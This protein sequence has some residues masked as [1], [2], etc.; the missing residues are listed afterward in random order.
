[1]TQ[2]QTSFHYNMLALIDGI[3]PRILGL[4]DILKEYLKHRQV[5]VR[6][7]TEFELQKA[8]DRAH[9]LEGL[10]IALDH[11][12]EVIAVI[13]GSQ[14]TEEAQV[15]LMDKFGLSEIQARA[16]LAMQLRALTGLERK[17][18]E[19]EL[20]EL[21][22]LIA[23]LEAILADEQRV[24]AVIREELLEMRK[25]YADDRRTQIIG[26][27]MGKFSDEELIPDEQVVVTIT[28]EN[29]IKRSLVSEYR[30]QN[31]GG[32]GKRGMTTKEEDVIDKLVTASTHDWLLLFTNKGR[33][34]RLKVYEVPASGLTAKGVAVVNLIQLQPEEHVTSMIKIDKSQDGKGYL[35]MIT[36]H[37]VVKKTPITDYGNI[38]TSGLIAINLDDGDELRWIHLSSGDDEVI[39]STAFGQAIRFQE[40]DARSMGRSARGVRGIRLRPGDRVV[41][42]DLVD[43]DRQLL[44]LSK[45]GYGK[46]TKVS[47]FPAHKRGGVGIKAAV[48][49]GKTGD[50]I[51]VHSISPESQEILVISTKGQAIRIGVKDI[52]VLGRTTQGVRVMRLNGD[53]GVASVGLVAESE[54][55]EELGEEVEAS[56][57]A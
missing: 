23:E 25:A 44:V 52:P 9:I 32:K 57:E 16:I 28:T 15:N 24:L 53:D 21:R 5:V 33:V 55:A 46:L 11:I 12:D 37:G 26:Q 56:E 22:K 40:K 54:V 18:I 10:S 30:R 49:N 51:S 39:I 29:Y 14:S 3:Q 41:G 50:L 19:D 8:K 34:F 48:V 42:A 20:A 45:K 1:M 43:D 31:R 36:T 4:E 17:R 2:L 6:R 35:F 13:R 27:E 47:N 7:R 38:R